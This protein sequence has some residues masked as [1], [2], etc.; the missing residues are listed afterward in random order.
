MILHVI[1]RLRKQVMYSLDAGKYLNYAIKSY[2]KSDDFTRIMR[3]VNKRQ[4][5]WKSFD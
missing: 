2:V 4:N 1:F 5:T 3:R